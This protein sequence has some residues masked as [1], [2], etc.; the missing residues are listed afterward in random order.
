[1]K[2]ALLGR[3]LIVVVGLLVAAAVP[4][5]ALPAAGAAAAQPSPSAGDE[6]GS[7]SLRDALES[8]A[9]GHLEAK[10]KLDNSLK[11][12]QR[13][14]AELRRLEGQVQELS[15]EVAVI[16]ATSYRMG[17]LN[18]MAVLLNSTD[19]DAFLERLI[20]LDVLAQRDD[21]QLGAYLQARRDADR[22]KLAVDREVREQKAQLDQMA[23]RKQ[24]AERALAA[25]GGR[26][27][28]GFVNANS[29]I[30][31]PAQRG[32]NGSWPRE[33][34]T[35]DDP[36]TSGCITPRTLHAMREAKA[37]GFNRH[38]SCHRSGG[39]GEHPRGRACDFAAASGGFENVNA[40]GGD[41]A[42]GDRLAAYL[43]RNAGRLGVLY[44]IWYRQIWMDGTGWR[45]YSGGGGPSA[46]HTNHVHLSIL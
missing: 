39:G 15:A 3:R 14:S 11:A 13:Y 45:S 36:T 7:K 8:A 4:A 29:P 20:G 28:G 21:R 34:C 40:T 31:K 1:M 30:A 37:A 38:V 12:Q 32:A 19:P 22:A 43:V 41:K 6:G 2:K 26:S 16:A 46:T 18:G 33:S 5:V 42:Y 10:A 24:E 35:V 17:R 25:V 44:V 23:K 27:S 9:K